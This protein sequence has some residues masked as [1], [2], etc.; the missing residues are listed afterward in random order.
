MGPGA[1]KTNALMWAV[2]RPDPTPLEIPAHEAEH[3]MQ[4]EC[5]RNSACDAS[6]MLGECC[7]GGDGGIL[8]CCPKVTGATNTR[9]Y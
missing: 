7:P 6:G 2:S 5:K 9:R 1:S 4:P 8:A 3:R